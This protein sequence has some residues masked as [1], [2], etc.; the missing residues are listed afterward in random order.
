LTATINNDPGIPKEK[1]TLQVETFVRNEVA[2]VVQPE[3]P[4]PKTIGVDGS[5]DHTFTVR[6]MGE[7]MTT[8]DLSKTG[9]PSGWEAEFT[10]NRVVDDSIEDL[11]PMEIVDVVLK[12]TSPE[13]SDIMKATINIRF[14]S[15]E[16]L[17]IYEDRTT[18]TNM[19]IGISLNP[20]SPTSETM[21]PGDNFNIWFDAINNDPSSEHV[22]TL[23]VEQHDS[24]WPSNSFSFQ[25]TSPVTIGADNTR[26]MSIDTTVPT[27]AVAGNFRFTVKGVVD[28]RSGVYDSFDYNIRIN[29]RH[30]LQVEL[31][32]KINE[33]NINTKEES[34]VYL[35]IINNGNVMENV[36]I[37]IDTSSS[38]VEVRM[39]DA[40][41][42]IILNMAVNPSSDM[43]IKISF[44][45]KDTASNNE[46]INVRIEAEAAS[47]PTPITN[48]LKVVVELSRA[49]WFADYMDWAAI[50]IMM[51]VMMAGLLL[52]NPRKRRAQK[53]PDEEEKKGATHGAVA[54]Q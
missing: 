54:R 53:G 34:I 13:T 10:G 15:R 26:A 23:N 18:V 35:S 52:Y 8:V 7:F 33:F 30:E 38:N 22:I 20:T 24:N 45:A 28:G 16:F 4:D 5:V 41:T 12:V 51:L 46:V 50:I 27:S 43:E 44:K 14:Q 9:V 49:E 39:N 2:L 48:D 47:D 17:E 6:N 40:L 29:L 37:T 11:R 32:P 42:S 36:N 1:D 25:P 19:V 21:D 31:N 3:N